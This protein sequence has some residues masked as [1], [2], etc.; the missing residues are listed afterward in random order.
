MRT[1]VRAA[2][3]SLPNISLCVSRSRDAQLL[4][5]FQEYSYENKQRSGAGRHIG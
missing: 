5:N 1:A 4:S 2:C 3:L